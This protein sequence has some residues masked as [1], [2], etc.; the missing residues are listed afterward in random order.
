M[1]DESDESVDTSK[2]DNPP[3][4]TSVSRSKRWWWVIGGVALVVVLGGVAA[5]VVIPGGGH[6]GAKECPP[7]RSDTGVRSPEDADSVGKDALAVVDVGF[8]PFYKGPIH[9]EP[10]NAL[11]GAVVKNETD[12]VL[13]N[14]EVSFE[15][16]D[17]DGKDPTVGIEKVA[18]KNNDRDL[19]SQR[20][21]VL[22]PGQQTAVGG[23]LTTRPS[24]VEDPDTGKPH[25]PDP[26]D[27]DKLEL[28][29]TDVSGEW[30]K[31]QNDVHRFTKLKTSK[32]DLAEDGERGENEYRF[33]DGQMDE[34]VHLDYRVTSSECKSVKKLSPAAIAYGPDGDIIAGVSS[35]SHGESRDLGKYAPGSNSSVADHTHQPLSLTIPDADDVTAKVF[36]SAEPIGK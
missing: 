31:Q 2:K 8:S 21:P 28:K 27:Y 22:F 6:D 17:A 3:Q 5:L 29:M 7:V 23:S 18:A 10:D 33:P 30:W 35:D 32:V 24:L 9:T 16:S 26:V 4:S 19:K 11:F 36:P 25:E 1:H 15:L 13:Y 14:G 34:F 12:R 20:I